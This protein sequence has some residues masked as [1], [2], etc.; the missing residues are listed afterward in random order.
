MFSSNPDI[1]RDWSPG[2]FTYNTAEGTLLCVDDEQTYF[3]VNSHGEGIVDFY[4]PPEENFEMEL[5]E[6]EN[7]T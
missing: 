6:E 5:E 4:Q 2:V 7:G 3:E 1:D